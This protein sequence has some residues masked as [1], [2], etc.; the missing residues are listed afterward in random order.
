MRVTGG[1]IYFEYANNNATLP[2]ATGWDL[3]TSEA[4]NL[5]VP[6]TTNQYIYMSSYNTPSTGKSY[7]NSFSIGP[8]D[9]AFSNITGGITKPYSYTLAPNPS[10]GGGA[11]SAS[12]G[13]YTSNVTLTLSGSSSTNGLIRHYKCLLFATGSVYKNTTIDPGYKGTTSLTYQ[14]MRSSGDASSGYTNIAGATSSPY[15][16]TGAPADGSGRYY[17]STVSMTGATS[18]NSSADRGYRLGLVSITSTGLALIMVGRSRT[19]QTL[20]IPLNSITITNTGNVTEDIAVSGSDMVGTV[21]WTLSD[22]AE[23]GSNIYWLKAGLNGGSYNTTIRKTAP[24]LVL[25]TGI[26]VSASQQI[27]IQLY[28]PSV[29]TDGST[30]KGTVSLVV[31]AH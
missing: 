1:T 14:W 6:L 5:G 8:S 4:W 18:V 9:S 19:N 2:S 25:I 20:S 12:D 28:T 17:L 23:I 16:D 29:V 15:G 22:T 13:L 7:I 21:N 10:L 24:Y 11:A 31:T 26:A 27:G 3:L 30:K